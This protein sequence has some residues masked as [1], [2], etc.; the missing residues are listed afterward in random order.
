VQ[1]CAIPIDDAA[2]CVNGSSVARAISRSVGVRRDDPCLD[3]E[4]VGIAVA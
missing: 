3:F 2:A 1:N 4:E